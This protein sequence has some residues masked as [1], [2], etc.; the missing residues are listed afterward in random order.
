MSEGL[1]SG[2]KIINSSIA[3]ANIDEDRAGIYKCIVNTTAG[4]ES[5]AGNFSVFC[6]LKIQNLARLDYAGSNAMNTL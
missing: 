5:S 6:K 4:S 2:T 3:I 1:L